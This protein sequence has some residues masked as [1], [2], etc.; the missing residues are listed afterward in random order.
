MAL[1]PKTHF[2]KTRFPFNSGK[3][4]QI[5]DQQRSLQASNRRSSHLH[6]SVAAQPVGKNV[7]CSIVCLSMFIRH[8]LHRNPKPSFLP[9]SFFT[10]PSLATEDTNICSRV[11]QCLVRS[12]RDSRRRPVK[13]RKLTRLAL[14]ACASN[15]ATERKRSGSWTPYWWDLKKIKKRTET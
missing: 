11:C 8:K 3:R 6:S 13:R 4:P 1:D 15:P 2:V 12:D 5:V 14:K 9:S 10:S 7:A